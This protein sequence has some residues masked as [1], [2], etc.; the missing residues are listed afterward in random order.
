M[1]TQEDDIKVKTTQSKHNGTSYILETRAKSLAHYPHARLAGGM[2]Y[3]SGISSRRPDNSV[4]GVK[5]KEDGSVEKDIKEQ[6]KAVI[7]NIEVILKAAGAGLNNLVD[8][9]VFLVDMRDYAAYNEVYNTYFTA[10]HGPSRTT[11]QVVSLPGPHLLIE[12]K[13]VALCPSS[14]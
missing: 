12:I 9:T 6:T 14:S 7:E 8:V 11:V 1:S 10:E 2:L 13:A 5:V 4:A 3:V